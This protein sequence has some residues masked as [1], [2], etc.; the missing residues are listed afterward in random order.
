ML[1]K[2]SEEAFL[3]EKKTIDNYAERQGN[4]RGEEWKKEKWHKEK[5]LY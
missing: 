5:Q 2:I 4:K 1:P 3:L